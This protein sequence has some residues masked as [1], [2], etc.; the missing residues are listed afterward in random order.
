M[1]AG[2]N[3]WVRRTVGPSPR[4]GQVAAGLDAC[5]R[6]WFTWV[7]VCPGPAAPMHH[8]SA[9]QSPVLTCDEGVVYLLIELVGTFQPVPFGAR[10]VY[11]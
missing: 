5:G 4:W 10:L 9:K 8:S 6:V 2:R 11:F 3:V 1:S 7:H